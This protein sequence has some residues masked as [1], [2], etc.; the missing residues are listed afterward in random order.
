MVDLVLPQINRKKNRRTITVRHIG[1]NM[2]KEKRITLYK[3]IW[4][5]IRYWQSLNDIS[6]E[7]LATHLGVSIR[8]IK[9]YDKDASNI[10]LQ[11]LDRFLYLYDLS[12]NELLNT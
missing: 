7:E 5:K 2:K 6:D 8:T 12:L 4:C 1:E 9:E 11:K 3:K 10:T